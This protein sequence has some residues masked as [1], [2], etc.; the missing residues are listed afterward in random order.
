MTD[1]YQQIR[2]SDLSLIGTPG[3]VAYSVAGWPDEAL[4]DLDG[5]DERFGLR[6][7]AFWPVAVSDPAFDPDT[8]ALTDEVTGLVIDKK[9]FRF[10]GTR[11]VR[12]LT[13]E[14]I[15]ARN[16]IPDNPTLGD[17]RVAL[18]LWGRLGDVLA[19]IKAL[20][21]TGNPL[22]VVAQERVEY[23][24]NVLL[25]QLLQLKDVFGFTEADVIESLWR[26]DRVSKGD[27]S[28]EW[29]L[30]NESR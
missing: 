3:P 19:R 13:A 9:V 11:G 27:L 2:R 5:T 8:Q 17:W 25:A 6:G 22:G 10:T 23:S 30:P 29:P 21:D 1:A 7:T 4:R 15:A 28:G 18:V 12:A 14:E 24:N 16:P 20:V 26:A